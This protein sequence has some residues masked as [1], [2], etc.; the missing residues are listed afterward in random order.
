[1]KKPRS[2]K[3]CPQSEPLTYRTGSSAAE[4]RGDRVSLCS[5]GAYPGSPSVDQAD[6]ELTEIHLPLPLN[7]G[8]KGVRYHHLTEFLCVA[9]ADLEFTLQTRLVWISEV[10]LLLPPEYWN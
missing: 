1:M 10:C 8:I 7:A 2:E 3:P 6:L 5:F 4:T 9:L